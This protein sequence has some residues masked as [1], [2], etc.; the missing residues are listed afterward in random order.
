MKPNQYHYANLPGKVA[1]SPPATNSSHLNVGGAERI[2]S[3][4]AGSAMSYYAVRNPGL[5]GLLSGL[6]GGALLWRGATGYCFLNRALG[7]DTAHGQTQQVEVTASLTINRPRPQVYW[8]WR[9]LENLPRFMLHLED[10][11]QLGPLRSHWVARLP[12]GLGKIE[13]QA[14]IIHEEENAVIDW[15]SQPGSD[16]DN[17]GE[18]RFSD[19]PDNQGTVVQALIS[20]RPPAGNVGDLAAR[21]LNPSF[22]ELVQQDLHRFKKMMET[23]QVPAVA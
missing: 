6:V 4:L 11:R 22:E 7:R 21:L 5:S 10:V 9:Q 8:F 16:I 19:A 20:Y 13:W 15:R 23:G 2:A 18:I 3:V 1:V 12:R 17:A 14:D